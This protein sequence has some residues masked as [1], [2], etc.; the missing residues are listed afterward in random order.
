MGKQTKKKGQSKDR[1]DK[2]ITRKLQDKTNHKARQD[3]HKTRQYQDKACQQTKQT[4][5]H[6]NTDSLESLDVVRQ[7]LFW[8]WS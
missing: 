4:D 8:C 3:N 5:N 1:Q 2:K 6:T 7:A